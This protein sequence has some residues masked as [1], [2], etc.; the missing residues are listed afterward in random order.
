MATVSSGLRIYLIET[1]VYDYEFKIRVTVRPDDIPPK[2]ELMRIEDIVYNGHKVTFG[3]Q[4]KYG[5]YLR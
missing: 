1:P 3:E 5:V 4:V 2:I